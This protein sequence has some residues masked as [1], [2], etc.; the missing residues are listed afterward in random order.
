MVPL[1]SIII[2]HFSRSALLAEAVAS[3]RASSEQN[4]EIIIVDDGSPDEDWCAI[5]HLAQGRTTVIQRIDGIKGPSR[6]RNI[7]LAEAR[8]EFVVFLDSDDWMAPWCLE[9]RIAA[10]HAHPLADLVVFPVLLFTERPGDLDILWNSLDSSR[11]DLERFASSDPPWHTSSPIWRTNALRGIGGFNEAVFYGDDSD[12]HMR[13]LAEGMKINKETEVVPDLFIRRSNTPRITNSLSPFL[14]ASRL[15]RLREGSLFLK[16]KPELKH[17][18]D[19][20]EGQYFVEAEFLLFNHESADNALRLVLQDWCTDCRPPRRRRWG[21]ICY[22]AVALAFRKRAYLI[23]RVARRIAK[24]LVPVSYFPVGGSFHHA[25]A[26]VEVMSD[27][28]NRMGTHPVA[29]RERI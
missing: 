6:C 10:I 28:L 13:A 19:I 5:Q 17:I 4:F 14:V 15:T 20:W 11:S 2:P 18:M 1:I 22:F 9:H 21:V 12:L 26:G 23:L 16:S 25:K 8:G 24:A 7:G 27:L 29:D 3:V